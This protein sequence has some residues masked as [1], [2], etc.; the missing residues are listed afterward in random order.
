MYIALK[1]YHSTKTA[2]VRTFTSHLTNP[3]RKTNSGKSS[4]GRESWRQCASSYTICI[5]RSICIEAKVFTNGPGDQS[6]IPGRVIPDTKKILLDA[7]W[8]NIHY[9]KVRNKG[10]WNNLGKGVTHLL[11]VGVVDIERSPS[12]TFGHCT[13]LYVSTK[14][15]GRRF[16]SIKD[17]MDTS[18]R[19]LK[20]YI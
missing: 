1:K 11:H 9:Y 15:G 4:K 10:K 5:N 7:F 13:C 18:K 16:N 3:S 8:F 20:V 2:V 19:V 6:S 12:T 17:S 14:E